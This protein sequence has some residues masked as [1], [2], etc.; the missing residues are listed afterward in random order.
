MS[1]E[2]ESDSRIDPSLSNDINAKKEQQFE[3]DAEKRSAD[4]HASIQL[5]NDEKLAQKS[6]VKPAFIAK[7]ITLL[8]L[9]PFH[10]IKTRNPHRWPY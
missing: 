1:V 2:S 6:G 4:S 9:V 8:Q 10:L 5:D 7:A 3:V